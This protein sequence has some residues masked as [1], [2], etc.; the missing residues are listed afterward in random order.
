MMMIF[1]DQIYI[2]VLLM[3]KVFQIKKMVTGP[4]LVTLTLEYNQHSNFFSK[5]YVVYENFTAQT[6]LEQS[7]LF[8]PKQKK[9]IFFTALLFKS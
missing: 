6:F 1:V 4:S 8:H 3:G 7:A 5:K 9:N 2:V